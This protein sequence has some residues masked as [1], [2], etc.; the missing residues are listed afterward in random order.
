ML[1]M[2]LLYFISIE[3]NE[4]AKN[5]PVVRGW[6][7]LVAFRLFVRHEEIILVKKENLQLLQQVVEAPAAG[8]FTQCGETQVKGSE[9]L[10]SIYDV[11][12]LDAAKGG[13][14]FGNHQ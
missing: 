8:D 2:R 11:E 4:I 10:L 12:R 3:V 13:F 6:L 1:R 5:R 14:T 9:P 7:K